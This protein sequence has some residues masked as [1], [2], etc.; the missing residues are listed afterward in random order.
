MREGTPDAHYL[1]SHKPPPT[2]WFWI[3]PASWAPTLPSLQKTSFFSSWAPRVICS[4]RQGFHIVVFKQPL[5]L[6]LKIL[7]KPKNTRSWLH[8]EIGKGKTRARN[9]HRSHSSQI[10]LRSENKTPVHIS[11]SCP[12]MLF[13]EGSWETEIFHLFW[14]QQNEHAEF[15]FRCVCVCVC[16]FVCVCVCLCVCVSVCVC[17]CVCVLMNWIQVSVVSYL[18]CT[19]TKSVYTQVKKAFENIPL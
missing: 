13:R 9:Q 18:P 5:L 15:Q 19:N 3:L 6:T 17:L 16:V 4:G 10:L 2:S 8:F 14:E 1:G 11:I 7:L 12:S